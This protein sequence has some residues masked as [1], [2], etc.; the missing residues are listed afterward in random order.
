M[1]RFRWTN[2][3]K[4]KSKQIRKRDKYLC[5]I[6]L[7]KLYNTAAQYNFTN[8]EVHHIES[9]AENWDKRLDDGNLISLC[10]YHHK[11]ADSRE[12]P[13]NILVGIVEQL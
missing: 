11:M 5:Q 3:W 8:I 13:K 4:N 9:I 7:R 1:N 2:Q 6:C 12:I 10:A